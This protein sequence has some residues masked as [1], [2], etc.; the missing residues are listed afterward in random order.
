MALR[1]IFTRQDE[2]PGFQKSMD[3][4]LREEVPESV[5]LDAELSESFRTFSWAQSSL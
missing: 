4:D 3:T 5:R 1:D 2:F